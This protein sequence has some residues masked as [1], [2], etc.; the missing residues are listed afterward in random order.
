MGKFGK[1]KK[2]GLRKIWSKEASDFTP[3]LSSNITALGEALGLDLELTDRESNVG[4][5]SLD[6]LARDLGTSRTVIIENQLTQTDHDHLGKLLT[7]AAGFGASIVIWVSESIRD[8]HR[9]ALDWLNQ[10]TD[11]DTQFFGVVI[12]VLQI[13]DSKAAYNFKPV[14]FPNEWQKS[15]RRQLSGKV[16]SKGEKY[17]QYFQTLID[18][19]REKYKFT[20]ARIGQ[21]QNWYSFSSGYSGIPYAAVFAQG[22][23]V[24]VEIYI[25]QGD[26]D[27]NKGL[28]DFLYSQKEK[29]EE[30]S[31]LTIEWERLDDKRA[32]RTA[33]YRDGSIG[34]SDNELEEIR[35]WHV[36]KLLALKNVFNPLLKAGLKEVGRQ[37]T[38]TK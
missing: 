30:E 38:N 13:D 9:Q 22:G 35:Q 10:R 7:Y 20:G 25:D 31:G 1:L 3:W 15:R 2:L 32:S 4:D 21:P 11:S 34:D 8:E 16:S 24:R 12:E 33:V 37:S 14:V 5:F 23:R 28:F 29:I 19:L 17:R 26:F 18:E 36:G 27:K 6:L